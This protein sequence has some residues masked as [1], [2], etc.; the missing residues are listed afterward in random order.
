M[1]ELF[2]IFASEKTISMD[3]T[4]I[5]DFDGTLLD[6][7][8]LMKYEYL[9]K[10]PTRG[11][12]EWSKGRKEYL[13][14]IKDCKLYEGMDEVIQHIRKNHIKCAV[15]TANTKDRVVEAIKAF[16]WSDFINKTNIIGCYSLGMNRASKDDGD[17]RLFAKALELMGVTADDC[18]AFGN[19]LNDF[20]AAQSIGIKAYNCL[21]GASD[22]ERTVMMNEMSENS[23]TSPTDILEIIGK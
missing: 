21:W 15:V 19:E 8:P 2:C 18:I 16:G 4:I 12:K 1:S 11:T 14:H 23:I 13:S 9:F 6:T 20:K 10:Q 22:D 3:C 17:S 5:F 7:Q